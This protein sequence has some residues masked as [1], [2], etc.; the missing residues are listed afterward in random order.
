VIRCIT[1][2]YRDELGYCSNPHIHET[3]PRGIDDLVYSY[4]EDGGFWVGPAFG[5]IHH[6]VPTLKPK[7]E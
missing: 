3:S 7:G 2:I 4:A 5:C 1:C 6:T